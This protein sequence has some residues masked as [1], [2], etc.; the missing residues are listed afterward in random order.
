MAETRDPKLS[1]PPPATW[2]C[3]LPPE[4]EGNYVVTRSRPYLDALA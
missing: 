1:L 3:H 4:N 2:G